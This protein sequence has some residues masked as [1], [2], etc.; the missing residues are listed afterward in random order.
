MGLEMPT[1]LSHEFETVRDVN[2]FIVLDLDRTLL[3]SDLLNMFLCEHIDTSCDMAPEDGDPRMYIAGQRGNSFSVRN[4][5]TQRYGADAYE[6][7]RQYILADIQLGDEDL[8]YPGVRELIANLE[9]KKI[10]FGIVTFSEDKENQLFKLDVFHQYLGRAHGEVEAI[11]TEVKNKAE[12]VENEWCDND[13]A[14]ESGMRY[15]VPSRLSKDGRIRAKHILIVD[16]KYQNTI[17]S[18]DAIAAFVVKEQATDKPPT[19]SN[20]G[21]IEQL[22]D[23]I[24][25]DQLEDYVKNHVSN[26]QN[27]G[28]L[29]F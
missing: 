12:W 13:D 16:D 9:A 27:D 6:T 17:S 15:S 10:P 5:L 3:R 14:N 25:N 4:Y 8:L 20:G 1:V 19:V 24:V 23:I 11:V 28:R 18:H 22:A 7:V 29:D 21:T 26:S 2:I